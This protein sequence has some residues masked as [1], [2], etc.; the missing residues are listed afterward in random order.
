MYVE[1]IRKLARN[2]I[3]A[4]SLTKQVRD[5]NNDLGKQNLREGFKET[6]KPLIESQHSVKKSVDKQQDAMIKE[7]QANQLALTQGLNQSRLAITEGFD[8]MG[9]VKRRHMQQ[10]PGFEAIEGLKKSIKFSDI[11]RFIWHI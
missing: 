4:D 6:F 5:K 9:E 8:K 2:T 7:L 11:N 10:L 3:E 1:E